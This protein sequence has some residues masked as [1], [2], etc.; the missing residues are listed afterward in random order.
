M[1]GAI[2]EALILAFYKIIKGEAR[3]ASQPTKSEEL[4]PPPLF[5]RERWNKRVCD[6]IRK[7]EGSNST[8]K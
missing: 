6:I 4:G 2:I 7:Q 8:R 5:I 1:I 3:D